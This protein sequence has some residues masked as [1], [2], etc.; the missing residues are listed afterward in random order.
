MK[1]FRCDDCNECIDKPCAESDYYLIRDG[2]GSFYELEGNLDLCPKCWNKMLK[3]VMPN[4]KAE[5]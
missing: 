2:V 4:L 3:E 1:V 5:Q